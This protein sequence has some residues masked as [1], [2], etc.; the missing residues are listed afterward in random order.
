MWGITYERKD[1][2]EGDL[3]EV[4]SSSPV[5]GDVTTRPM[6]TNQRASDSVPRYNK[7]NLHC[8][9]ILGLWISIHYFLDIMMIIYKNTR[10]K[11]FSILGFLIHVL[12]KGQWTRQTNKVS[13]YNPKLKSSGDNPLL[14]NLSARNISW[15]LKIYGETDVKFVLSLFDEHFIWRST[16]ESCTDISKR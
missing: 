12:C 13:N 3:Q 2:P 16:S 15:T 1:V 7:D 5:T 9:Y 6:P 11:M 8:W 4:L 14:T 10:K